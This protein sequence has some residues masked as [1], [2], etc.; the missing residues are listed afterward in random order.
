[1]LTRLKH[2]SHGAKTHQG[3]R[4]Y[5]AN[6]SWMFAE[7]I[8]RL[9]AGLFVG[10]WVA[11]YLG[12]NQFGVFSYALALVA[13]FGSVA[14]LGMD[15]IVV[16]ELVREPG[17]RDIYLGT[18][19]W[20]RVIAAF[21]TLGCISFAVQYTSN[22]HATNVYVFIIASGMIFQSFEVIDY[23][24]QAKVLSRF[25]ALC[26]MAQLLISS[27]LKLYFILTGAELIWFV[28]ISLIDQFTLAI[29]LFIAYR[30]Q[31]VGY[32]YRHFDLMTAK[33][34]LKESWPLI[35]SGFV[36]MIY[37]RIDQV[38]IKEMLGDKEVGLYSA[39]V[40][41][42][43]IWYFIPM[44]ITQAVFP[45]I[46]NAKKQSEELYY[47]RLQRLYSFMAWAAICI[48][49]PM[50]FLS[51]WLVTLLYGEA[52]KIAGQVLMINIWGGVFVFLGVS[53]GCWYLTENLQ[54]LSTVNTTMGAV[55]NESLNFILIPRYGIYGA[56]VAT[57]LSQATSAYLMNLVF[58][59]TR[60]NFMRLSSSFLLKNIFKTSR[61]TKS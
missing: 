2:L 25:V 3:F 37:M 49:L 22:D 29:T 58:H 28:T 30:Y 1:M 61:L 5:F 32:F 39:A 26:K 43:G 23:Y 27:L 42:S 15:R 12:P 17:S 7:R 35:F 57:V 13:I 11:R 18:A 38:M 4:R 9:I 41:L 55:A 33:K 45:A 8:L 59:E 34:L 53:S 52:Y 6:T 56:A 16:R 48:A 47:M 31:K 21:V 40:T 46:I 10:V 14:Q 51:D 44:I 19:F 20:L 60:N 24:F 50:T 54:R 36:I